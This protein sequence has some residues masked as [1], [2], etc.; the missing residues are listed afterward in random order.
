MELPGETPTSPSITL[1]PVLVTAEPPKT[2]KLCDVPRKVWASATN[3]ERRPN[4]PR[5]EG[6]E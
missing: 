2:P 6:A 1:E 5:W 4:C 3:P